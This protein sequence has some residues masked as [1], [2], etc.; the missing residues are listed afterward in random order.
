VAVDDGHADVAF[1][2]AGASIFSRFA[3]A[4]EPGRGIQVDGVRRPT[5]F[6]S[7]EKFWPIAAQLTSLGDIS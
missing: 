2:L 4:R 1:R 5:T 6:D 7:E 3:Q